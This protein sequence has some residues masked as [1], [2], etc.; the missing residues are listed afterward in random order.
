VS[1]VGSAGAK[2]PCPLVIRHV[3]I[4]TFVPSKKVTCL[5]AAHHQARALG[6]LAGLGSSICTFV[7]VKQVKG[8]PAAHHQ[9]RA[10]GSL[11]GLGSTRARAR[12]CWRWRPTSAASSHVYISYTL[13]R[14]T[15]ILGTYLKLIYIYIYTYIH[16]YI[17]TY[18]YIYIYIYTY[19]HIYIHTYIYTYNIYTYIHIYVHIYMYIYYVYIYI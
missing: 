16:T 2:K 7:S 11:P 18:E 10:L 5:P 13:A 3:S 8:V 12:S 4:C 15:Y 19:I 1:V 6:S 14:S 9:A 17:H